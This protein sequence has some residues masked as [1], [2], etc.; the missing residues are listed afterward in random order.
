MLRH[1]YAI[2]MPINL[3]RLLTHNIVSLLVID[4][5]RDPGQLFDS[6]CGV[7]GQDESSPPGTGAVKSEA[8][9]S[10]GGSGGGGEGL[11]QEMNALLARR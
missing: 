6:G 1:D 8:N 3:S 11:M 10:S 5:L 2:L 4:L 9:R 7:C